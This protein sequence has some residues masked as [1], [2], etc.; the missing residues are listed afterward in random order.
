MNVA[1]AHSDDLARLESGLRQLKTSYDKYFA[2]L[3]RIEPQKERDDLKKLLARLVG[4]SHRGNNTARRFRLQTFQAKLTSH[5]QYWNRITRQIEEGTFKRDRLRADRL[6]QT[7]ESKPM[8]A[9]KQ[10]EKTIAQNSDVL[11]APLQELYTAFNQTRQYLGQDEPIEAKRFV[12]TLAKQYRVL[13]ERYQ[14][15]NIEFRVGVKEGRAILKAT[16]R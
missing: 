10:K 11:P 7:F 13:Q 12:K 14:G 15:K 1:T 16:V 8:N 9:T 5:E 3:E 4:E 2:G 6:V